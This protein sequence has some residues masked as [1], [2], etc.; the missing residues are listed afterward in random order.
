ML[1]WTQNTLA[2]V[3]EG[4][5]LLGAELF[6]RGIMP[7]ISVITITSRDEP[8]LD[9]MAQCLMN[10]TFKDFEWVIVDA[11]IRSRSEDFYA[12]IASIVQGKFPIR[13]VEP[14][15]SIYH[16]F[17]MPAISNARNSGILESEG[18]LLVWID[19]NIWIKSDHLERHWNVY[20][21]GKESGK[22]YYMTGLGWPF[23]DWSAVSALSKNEPFNEGGKLCREG[24]WFKNNVIDN[25]RTA[26]DCRAYQP[27]PWPDGRAPELITIGGILCEKVTGAW[28]YGRNMSMP[29]DAL[30]E[31]NGNDER[32]DGTPDS[33][34]ID[35][36]LRLNNLGYTTILDRG[37]VSYKYSGNSNISL[38]ISQPFLWG[39][40][41]EV[42][43]ALANRNQ[44][45]L[46]EVM[47][48][49]DRI[50]ANWFNLKDQIANFREHTFRINL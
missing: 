1:G 47:H 21:F 9:K 31:I 37:C 43:G 4:S 25:S 33:Q 23:S 42:N 38:Q 11:K 20:S 48:R 24:D 44:F 10:Q 49:P 36:G 3:T 12:I 50:K 35:S 17:N 22:K 7:K 27:Y 8:N 32:Y 29:L 13:V 16:D 34:D 6:G 26:D 19:D 40:I 28:C 5:I 15:W 14:K 46:W 39:H 18:E 2:A 41:R 30:F 45:N